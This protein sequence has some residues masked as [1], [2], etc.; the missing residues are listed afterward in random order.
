M[1][2][3]GASVGLHKYAKYINPSINF[4]ET[5]ESFFDTIISINFAISVGTRGMN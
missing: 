2:S 5:Q 4:L 1:T 3:L